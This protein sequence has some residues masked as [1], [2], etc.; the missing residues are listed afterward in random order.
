MKILPIIK[1]FFRHP[2]NVLVEYGINPSEEDL[3]KG[4]DLISTPEKR[5]RE[6]NSMIRELRDC[7]KWISGPI[8]KFSVFSLQRT[9]AEMLG[10][11]VA[12]L[13]SLFLL[14]SSS[15]WAAFREK[16]RGLGDAIYEKLRPVYKWGG[17]VL[18]SAGILSGVA[19]FALRKR[20]NS[21]PELS[22]E[23]SDDLEEYVR[24]R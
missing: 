14:K 16:I 21:T 6:V 17:I 10:G 20:I 5:E 3:S 22:T 13:G 4:L 23:R 15:P 12:V 8:A 2:I 11:I 9:M 7:P 1:S 24:K 18:G 19:G